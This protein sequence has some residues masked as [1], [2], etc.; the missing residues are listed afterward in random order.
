MTI[1]NW[2]RSFLP[3]CLK[4]QKV[5]YST[6]YS[7]VGIPAFDVQIE[8]GHRK[9]NR[10]N[11]VVSN[12]ADFPLVV[13]ANY[14]WLRLIQD[15]GYRYKVTGKYIPFMDDTGTQPSTVPQY[16]DG[17][18]DKYDVSVNGNKPK[19]ICYQTLPAINF[20]ITELKKI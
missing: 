19:L 5:D 10:I 12:S 7:P 3:Y 20:N 14:G 4:I 15:R 2:S 18:G 13:G 9:N 16:L 1:G 6:T 17:T 11:D 8:L